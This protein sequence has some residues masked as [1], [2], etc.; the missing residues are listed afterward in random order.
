M[1]STRTLSGLYDSLAGLYLRDIASSM[2][3]SP[4]ENR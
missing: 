1:N 2:K 4:C 3:L